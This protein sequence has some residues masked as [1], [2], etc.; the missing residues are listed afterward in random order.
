MLLVHKLPIPPIK[1]PFKHCKLSREKYA[2]I[3][4]NIATTYA[5]GFVLALNNKWGDGKTTFVK[6]WQQSLKN[7]EYATLYFN[8]WENDFNHDPMVAILSELRSL[9]IK[10]Q[11]AARTLIKKGAQ[12]SLNLLPILVS[13]IAE[14]YINTDKISE[15]LQKLSDNATNL[16]EEQI[17]DYASKKKGIEDF[18]NELEKYIQN[19]KKKPLIF[20]IDEL[21]RC[22]PKYAVEVLEHI[23][24]FFSVPGIVF[25]LS[26]DKEQLG[27]CIKGY[28]GSHELDTEEYLRRFIDLEFSL[29]RPEPKAYCDYLFNYY[30]FNEFFDPGNTDIRSTIKVEKDDFINTTYMLFKHGGLTPRHM[31]KI[32]ILTRVV[33]NSFHQNNYLFIETLLILVYLKIIHPQTYQDIKEKKLSVQQLSNNLFSVFP[34]IE[35]TDRNNRWDVIETEL[36]FRYNVDFDDMHRSELIINNSDTRELS[37]KPNFL[38]PDNHKKAIKIIDHFSSNHRNSDIGLEYLIEK[39]DLREKFMP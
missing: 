37:Y 6:M 24:H 15:A 4:T 22:N 1:E 34:H 17:N 21:D 30:K 23:K 13:A 35:I 8:A 3:L 5:D 12:L 26:M 39:I 19:L 11:T 36:L 31:E 29:P 14:K 2:G 16:L 25:V 9:D 18:Q 38:S 32:F 33:I 10:D 7:E 27:H 28:F 20:I